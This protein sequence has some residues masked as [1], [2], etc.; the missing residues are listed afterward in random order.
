MHGLLHC[1]SDKTNHLKTS[2]WTLV[3]YTGQRD[4]HRLFCWQVTL[5]IKHDWVPSHQSTII[6]LNYSPTLFVCHSKRII[7][8]LFATSSKS[9]YFKVTAPIWEIIWKA[10]TFMSLTLKQH[11]WLPCGTKQ[12]CLYYY[13]QVLHESILPAAAGG[14]FSASIKDSKK[15][16]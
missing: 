4:V 6:F 8:M 2:P 1:W 3:T 11:I 15:T 7:N 5:S 14:R 9:K 12:H 13:S 16:H 10:D